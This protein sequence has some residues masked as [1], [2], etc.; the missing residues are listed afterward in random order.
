M[1]SSTRRGL[2]ATHRAYI[3]CLGVEV[4]RSKT[5]VMYDAGWTADLFNDLRAAC[6]TA[7]HDQRPLIDQARTIPP[8]AP[9]PHTVVT[10]SRRLAVFAEYGATRGWPLPY[11]RGWLWVLTNEPTRDRML[12]VLLT[13]SYGDDGVCGR[14]LRYA[15]PPLLAPVAYAAGLDPEEAEARHATGQLDPDGLY[16]LTALRGYHPPGDWAP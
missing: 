6:A 5:T 8:R 12:A 14:W 9:G 4:S 7:V 15:V 2:A 10:L 13:A 3:E 1:S 11:V 16:L